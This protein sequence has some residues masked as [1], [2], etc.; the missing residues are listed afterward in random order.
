MCERNEEKRG[1]DIVRGTVPGQLAFLHRI[2]RVIFSHG[3]LSKWFVEEYV[4]EECHDDLDKI[5]ETV[6]MFDK[7]RL[8]KEVSPIW[9]RPQH[10][11]GMLYKAGEYLQVVGHTPVREITKEGNLISCDV[12]STYENGEQIGTQEFLL[13]DTDTWEYMGIYGGMG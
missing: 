7:S 4:P 9:Y 2:D 3:G 5:I 6:N 12:F 13:L 8:W 10:L 1:G 11:P